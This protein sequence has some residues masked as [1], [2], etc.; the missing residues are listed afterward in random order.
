[1][2]KIRQSIVGLVARMLFVR[3]LVILESEF[4]D[5]TEAKVKKAPVTMDPA[6]WENEKKAQPPILPT[7]HRVYS[8]KIKQSTKVSRNLKGTRKYSFW[9]ADDDMYLLNHWNDS[10][11][12]MMRVL[13]RTAPAIHTRRCLL[14]KA[15]KVKKS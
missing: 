2:S 13:G 4:S 1:M 14:K 3:D 8:N 11:D 9:T 6:F 10:V 12:S 7:E 5:K 15:G